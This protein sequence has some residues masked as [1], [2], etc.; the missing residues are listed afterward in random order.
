MNFMMPLQR[1][2]RSVSEEN[3]G[4]GQVRSRPIAN[5]KRPPYGVRFGE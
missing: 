1:W 4:D 2:L 3:S 5:M